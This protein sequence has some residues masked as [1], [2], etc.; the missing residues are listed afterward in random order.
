M[1]G[2]E[3]MVPDMIDESIK[4]MA[5]DDNISVINLMNEMNSIMNS[6]TQMK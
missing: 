1:P 3:P 5:S 2:D 4:L 6:V